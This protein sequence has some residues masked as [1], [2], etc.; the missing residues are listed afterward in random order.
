LTLEYTL[1]MIGVHP[2]QGWGLGMFESAFQNFMAAL[3]VITKPRN[4]ATP[5]Q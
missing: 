4:D 5:A 3:P 1:R 2:W